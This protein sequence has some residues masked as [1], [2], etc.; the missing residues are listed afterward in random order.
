MTLIIVVNCFTGV[1]TEDLERALAHVREAKLEG[2]AVPTHSLRLQDTDL[3][4][5]GLAPLAKKQVQE[6]LIQNN[7][8]A[9]ELDKKEKLLD[10]S[11]K[12]GR[13]LQ[14]ELEAVKQRQARRDDAE[15]TPR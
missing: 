1:S 3:S 4:K 15:M 8:L 12:M 7:E 10:I 13:T 2:G 6:I 9:L 14:E 11:Q 5:L